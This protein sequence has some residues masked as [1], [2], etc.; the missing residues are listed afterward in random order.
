MD[1][2]R[3]GVSFMADTCGMLRADES[4]PTGPGRTGGGLGGGGGRPL[5]RALSF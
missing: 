3:L 4:G 5:D 1:Y 2:E